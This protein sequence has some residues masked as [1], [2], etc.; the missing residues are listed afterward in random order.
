M[1]T[2]IIGDL[3]KYT[4]TIGELNYLNMTQQCH[5]EQDICNTHTRIWY[6]I[7]NKQLL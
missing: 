2:Y 6:N 3:D 1:K 5:S 7:K 4:F